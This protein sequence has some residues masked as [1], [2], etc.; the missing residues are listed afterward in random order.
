MGSVP[1][2]REISAVLP[3]DVS[4]AKISPCR[5][6]QVLPIYRVNVIS[7][8]FLYLITKDLREKRQGEEMAQGCN[9][10]HKE[11]QNQAQCL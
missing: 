2:S 10:Q 3:I 6:D 5:K 1:D 9:R 7:I 11:I 8:F 4:G